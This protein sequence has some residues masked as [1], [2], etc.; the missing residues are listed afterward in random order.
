MRL[1][2]PWKNHCLT[3]DDLNR[4][5]HFIKNAL[6]FDGNMKLTQQSTGLIW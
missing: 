4:N 2:Y 1:I 3:P 6:D 5:Y